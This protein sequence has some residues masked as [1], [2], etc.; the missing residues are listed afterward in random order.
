VDTIEHGMYLH[1]RPDLLEAMAAAGQV[2]V[3]TL[4][5][6][7]WMAGLEEAVDPAV[8]AAE[9]VDAA[10][11]HADPGMPPMLTGLARHNLEEGAASMRAARQAGVRIALGS[12]VSLAAGLEI[13]RMVHHGLTPAEAL[14]AATRIA[15][16]ALGLDEHIGTVSGG[17]LADLIVLNGDPLT[18]PGLLCD[19]A[20]VWLVLQGGT[21]VAGQALTTPV[22]ATPVPAAPVPGA[23]VPA[24][25]VPGSPVPASTAP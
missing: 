8:R 14:V 17:K 9:P 7:Y 20:R 6:Y 4:S 18:E 3:P 24:A 15:A 5:G 19:P 1:R 16:E 2:L 23:P 22:P 25:A 10:A 12:D 11:A 13:Q 21:V